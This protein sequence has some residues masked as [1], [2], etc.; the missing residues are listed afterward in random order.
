[1]YNEKT[2]GLYHVFERKYL[3]FSSRTFLKILVIHTVII[4]PQ[5]VADVSL[6]Q[7]VVDVSTSDR[8]HIFL[9]QAVVH[10]RI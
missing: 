9:S 3:N 1:M 2:R 4:L 5:A 10:R 6:S 8:K 7:A